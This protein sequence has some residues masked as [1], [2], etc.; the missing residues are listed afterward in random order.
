MIIDLKRTVIKIQISR[1]I[2]L[3]V[4]VIFLLILMIML[5]IKQT[6]FG[7]SKY[8]W[9]IIVAGI[10]VVYVIY[11]GILE[12]YYIYFSDQGEKI[13]LRYF[14]MSFYNDKKHTIEIPKESYSGY[15]VKRSLVGLKEKLILLERIKN[16]DAKYP[17]VSLSALSKTQKRNLIE[18]LERNKLVFS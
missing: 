3:I 18:A 5:D 17:A 7:L 1:F 12:P 4:L 14:S 9:S 2:T 8:Q 16:T 10:Y 13:I 11:Q 6:Y 15:E